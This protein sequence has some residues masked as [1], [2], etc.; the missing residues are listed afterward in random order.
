MIVHQL[1]FMYMDSISHI[2]V[3]SCM[4]SLGVVGGVKSILLNMLSNIV[5]S[6]SISFCCV[7]VHVSAAYR[8]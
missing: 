3:S 6:C 7:F 8:V 2:P 5:C 1:F 4:I